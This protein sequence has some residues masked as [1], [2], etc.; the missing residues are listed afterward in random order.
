M[1]ILNIGDRQQ[2]IS[3]IK[4]EEN[5]KRMEQSQEEFDILTGNI[6]PYVEKDL[7]QRFKP[8]FVKSLPVCSAINIFKKMVDQ[9]AAVYRQPPK[10]MFDGLSDDQKEKMELVYRDARVNFQMQESNKLYEAQKQQTHV[11]VEPKKGRMT[12]K[13]L[14]ADQLNVIPSKEDPEVAY[15]YIISAYDKQRNNKRTQHTDGLNQKIADSE[16][17]KRQV[18]RYIWWTDEYHFMTNGMG[19]VL[20]EGRPVSNPSMADLINP[21]EMMPIIEISQMKDYN[22]WRQ[23]SNDDANFTVAFNSD[24][25][26]AQQIVELQG[27][28]QAYLKGPKDLLP[29]E[30]EVGP[31]KILKLLTD[32]IEGDSVDFGYATPSSDVGGTTDF[33]LR[34]LALYLS[35]KGVDA[36][37]VSGSGDSDKYSSGLD[38]LLAQIKTME[39][40]RDAISLYEDAERKIYQVIVSW[41]NLL[42]GKEELDDKYQMGKVSDT[43]LKIKFAEPSIIMSEMDKIEYGE[44]LIENGV[45]DKYDLYAY[46]NNIER[47]DAI[48][49]LD[50]KVSGRENDR[51]IE[52]RTEGQP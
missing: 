5:N 18:E 31:S 16:D 7:C 43:E 1:D 25:T 46:L 9:R 14:K 34:K 15:G 12:V 23:V 38:R 21:I 41:L 2:V 4:G 47:V 45:W 27:F 30:I 20:I 3:E 33:M 19:E 35:S 37:A 52:D 40:S 6:R 22:Y 26:M 28:S 24:W 48:E 51:R 44:R 10:R 50:G 29:T 49:A 42:N 11:I 36:S 32:G 8:K 13:P 17:Y 39:S